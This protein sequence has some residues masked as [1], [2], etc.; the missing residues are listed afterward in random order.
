MFV[1]L[2]VVTMS[3]PNQPESPI[4][5]KHL[6]NNKIYLLCV[7]GLRKSRCKECGGSELCEHGLR[8]S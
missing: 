6:G 8:K 4:I 3:E 2:I 5:S 1:N 7:H